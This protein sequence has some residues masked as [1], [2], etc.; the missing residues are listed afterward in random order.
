MHAPLLSLLMMAHVS[1]SVRSVETVHLPTSPGTRQQIALHCVRPAAATRKAVLFIHGS[2]FPTMLAAGFE[3][4]PGDSWMDFMA[5][6]G[7][8]SCG[9]DFAGYG[10]SS[11]PPAMFQAPEGGPPLMRAP[12][13]AR[14][15]ALAIEY[16][17][18]Q[19]G[20]DD[21]H[22]VAHSWGTIPAAAFAAGHPNELASLTLFGPIVPIPGSKPAS[23][24]VAWFGITAE[25][26]LQEL[27]F[28][29]VLPKGLVLLEPVL[30]RKWATE[31][32]ASAPH[33]DG[34]PPDE[35][36]VPE[37][38]DVDIAAAHAGTYPY[39]PKQVTVPVFAVYANYDAE[40]NDAGATAFLAN[41]TASPLKWR[42]RIDEGTHVMHLERNRRSLYQSVL[43]FI[44][45]AEARH[46]EVDSR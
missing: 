6:R 1:G 44:K 16:L 11:R 4:A 35:I 10:A 33:V 30:A 17:R 39:S 8:L 31:F 2:S 34:D 38:P 23:A 27:F 41:F 19:R 21:M 45:A 3:F 22:L 9:L 32:A 42:L 14:E 28:K 5:K 7:F 18:K 24:R 12:E 43:A 37:G 20:V 46:G 40:V 29:D 15:I 13:A 25:E 26:R 36:R